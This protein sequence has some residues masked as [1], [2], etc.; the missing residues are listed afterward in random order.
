MIGGENAEPSDCGE[1]F[2]PPL[3]ASN[4]KPRFSIGKYQQLK[5]ERVNA[6]I[7]K[8][9]D[10]DAQILELKRQLAS[11]RVK[12]DAL[13]TKLHNKQEIVRRRKT[14]GLFN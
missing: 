10:T 8:L 5:K 2:S 1:R 9:L 14:K 4:K 12:I 7:H 6:E 11:E 3:A 13:G